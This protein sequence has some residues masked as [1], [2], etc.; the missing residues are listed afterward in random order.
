MSGG[1][2]VGPV[3]AWAWVQEAAGECWVSLP[4]LMGILKMGGRRLWT[5]VPQFLHHTAWWGEGRQLEQRHGLPC[6]WPE[7]G[8]AQ[9][10]PQSSFPTG[11]S[12]HQ[13]GTSWRPAG[14]S[15]KAGNQG[16]PHLRPRADKGFLQ[17]NIW[18]PSL[19]DQPPSS[20]QE[21]ALGRATLKVSRTSLPALSRLPYPPLATP[22]AGAPQ[23]PP[24]WPSRWFC[25]WSPS[26]PAETQSLHS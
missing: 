25:S 20:E 14:R 2:S 13:I 19:R 23:A 3:W 5:D 9:R 24:G 1:V 17:L 21:Q 12:G 22:W 8:R 4:T 18:N 7:G 6:C 26:P 15:Q 11:P 10:L 16:T